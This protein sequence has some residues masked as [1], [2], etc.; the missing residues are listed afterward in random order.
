MRARQPA[1]QDF[2]GA[3]LQNAFA[4]GESK[5]R[6]AAAA[7]GSKEHCSFVSSKCLHCAETFPAKTLK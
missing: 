2:E 3:A 5:Y 7:A 6:E 1:F 4:K